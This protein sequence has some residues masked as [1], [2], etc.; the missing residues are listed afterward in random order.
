MQEA[1]LPESI[2]YTSGDI[3]INEKDFKEISPR[4]L[5]T[6]HSR[7]RSIAISFERRPEHGY[8]VPDQVRSSASRT[9]GTRFFRTKLTCVDTP[10]YEIGAKAMAYLTELMTGRANKANSNVLIDYQIV[11][12]ESTRNE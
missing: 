11:W 1:G 3:N 6:S 4:A 10:V 9:P 8:K 12:R 2:I 5:P 7:P